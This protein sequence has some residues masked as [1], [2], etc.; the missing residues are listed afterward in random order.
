MNCA[1]VPL[2]SL[3]FLLHLYFIANFSGFSTLFR[4]NR[5]HMP[6]RQINGYRPENHCSGR[7]GN[8]LPAALA[9][10][11]SSLVWLLAVS[12]MNAETYSPSAIVPPRVMREIRGVWVASVGNIDWP[13]TNGL[14]TAQQKAELVALLDFAVKLKLNTIILQVRPSCDALYPSSLEPWSEYLTGTMGRA[15]EPYYDP[16]AFA[17]QEAH[18]RGLE[19]HAWF[20]PYRARHLRAKSPVSSNH[21]SRTHPE[22]VRHYGNSLWLDPGEKG[23][24][25]YSLRVT[26]DVVR[27]Y[28]IDGVHLDDYFYPY[29]EQDSAGKDLEFPDE[30]SW[31]RFGAGGRL[32]RDDWRRENVNA[33]V[34]ELYQSIKAIKPW[35]K[36]GISPFGIWRPGSPPQIKGLDSFAVL[37]ADSRKWL[38]S[39]WVDYLAPQL[40][41]GVAP[42]ETSFP[43][44]LKW[45]AQQN[46]KARLLCAGLYTVGRDWAPEEILH[47]IRLSREQAGVAGHVH[48]NMKALS[49]NGALDATLER[50]TYA[51]PALVP[52]TPWLEKTSPP[53]P[54]L[55]LRTESKAVGLNWTAVDSQI[56]SVWVLQTR[57]QGQ[58]TTQI[59]PGATRSMSLPGSPEAIALTFINRYGNAS[60]PAVVERR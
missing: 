20:N 50:E 33:F 17:I 49:R 11:L 32:S 16:L 15:P 23:V 35:V 44:L 53:K 55:Y 43:V 26:L 12:T 27:R 13:S 7:S 42:A 40:Y 47:Q 30:A 10:S 21:I 45:W 60:V 58:W 39:G 37:H 48:W 57:K 56:P 1:D 36:F 38:A 14:S 54:M 51:Q 18:R 25:Q 46:L 28:D 24:Q 2:F 6:V 5:W 3:F 59:L 29:K 31:R 4:E 19:L 34:H 41:W 9:V 22:W 52:A 8:R